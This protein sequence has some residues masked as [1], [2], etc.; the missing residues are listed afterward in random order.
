M[1][2]DLKLIAVSS[3]CDVGEHCSI[4]LK[5]KVKKG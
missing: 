2:V 1:K 5:I 3:A 4:D